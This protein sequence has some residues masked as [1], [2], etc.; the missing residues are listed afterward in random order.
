MPK[1]KPEGVAGKCKRLL[2]PEAN[3]HVDSAF[4]V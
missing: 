2:N 3:K 4:V 1:G